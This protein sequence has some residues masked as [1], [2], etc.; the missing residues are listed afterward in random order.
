MKID[1]QMISF[2]QFKTF[3]RMMSPCIDDYLYIHDTVEDVFLISSNAL[4]RFDLPGESMSGFTSYLEKLVS[5]ADYAEVMQD[6]GAVLSGQKAFHD[7]KYRWRGKNGEDVWVNCRGQAIFDQNK[8]ARYFVGCLNEIGNR[9]KADNISGLLSEASLYTNINNIN[10]N[11]EDRL[12]GFVL[13]VGIDNFKEINE[14]KGLDYGDMILKQTA[15]CIQKCIGEKQFLYR[16]VADE[17]AVVDFT[18]KTA[19]DAA[20][21]YRKIVQEIIHFIIDNHYEVFFTISGGIVDLDGVN[22]QKADHLMRITEFALNEAKRSGKNQYYIYDS[23]DYDAFR[24]K[25]WL[26]SVMRKSVN[27]G[28]RGFEAYYQPIVDMN[29]NHTMGAE[30]LLR[31]STGESGMVSPKD[32]I[33]LLEESGLIVPVG[34]WVLHQALQA[35][36]KIR[37]TIPEFRVSVNVSY[38][39]VLKSD[40]LGDIIKAL[41]L[42][43]LPPNSLMVELTE[44]GLFEEN[45]RFQRFCEGIQKMG[46]LL[47]LDDFGTGYSNF[48]YLYELNPNTIKIDRSFTYQAIQNE[49]EYNLLRHMIEMTHGIELKLCIEGIETEEELAKI[50]AMQPDYIQGYFF[51]KPCPYEKFMEDFVVQK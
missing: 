34:R 35:C 27:H 11:T 51:G 40:I 43:E 15:D 29:S 39:Q 24:H 9:Q 19:E 30:T 44:S 7:M 49:N 31:F 20:E 48:H 21:L 14:N 33:G 47:A 32:F 8:S 28:Y 12:H 50:G 16:V 13:R 46:V 18:D 6:I 45:V 22:N 25:K 36:K 38:V 23:E 42:Y 1:E 10:D 4:E 5:P 17:F 3:F 2:E 41:E 37:E 26:T